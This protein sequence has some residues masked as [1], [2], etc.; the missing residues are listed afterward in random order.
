[1]EGVV[2]EQKKAEHVRGDRVDAALLERQ[3]GFVN[4]C[5]ILTPVF[6]PCLFD[7]YKKGYNRRL[8]EYG[9]LVLGTRWAA[10]FEQV[11]RSTG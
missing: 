6:V 7:K 1:M 10:K 4:I 2:V 3:L 8:I 11:P 5:F 9:Q